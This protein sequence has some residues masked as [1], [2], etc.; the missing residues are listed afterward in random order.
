MDAPPS[1]ASSGRPGRRSGTFRDDETAEA[2]RDRD[3]ATVVDHGAADDRLLD[4]PLQR[5]AL[6]GRPALSVEEVLGA[7]GPGAVQ[8]DHREVA[9]GAD[10]DGALAR[11]DPEQPGGVAGGEAREV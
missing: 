4:P 11:V 8:V 6:Q 5:L 7:H 10:A 3:L 1:L 9:V 2:R